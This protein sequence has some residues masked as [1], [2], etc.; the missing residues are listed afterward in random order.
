MLVLTRRL[1]EE[2]IID[3]NIRVAI[4]GIRGC[5]VRLG[6]DAPKGVPIHRQEIFERLQQEGKTMIG[7][8][9]S[10]E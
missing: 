4:L 2:I 5:Q 9:Y 1:D 7:K 6:I 3:G 10:N 8:E